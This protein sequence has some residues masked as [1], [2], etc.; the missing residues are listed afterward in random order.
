MIILR[1]SCHPFR[2]GGLTIAL[3]YRV[4]PK[5][6]GLHTGRFFA[7]ARTYRARRRHWGRVGNALGSARNGGRGVYR[8]KISGA[9][10]YASSKQ[11]AAEENPR[12]TYRT[13]LGH[14]IFFYRR[15]P[16]SIFNETQRYSFIECLS[17]F[18]QL[19][20]ALLHSAYDEYP[21][22]DD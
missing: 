11:A 16:E 18:I 1:M 21:V 17:F 5:G 13:K 6:E 15:G 20:P 7:M 8:P 14:S 22:I 9:R 2:C 12:G 10:P 4:Q 3:A 19:L